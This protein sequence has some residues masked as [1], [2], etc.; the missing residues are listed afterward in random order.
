[1]AVN[2]EG[3]HREGWFMTT[4]KSSEAK[5]AG[6]T[7]QVR[8]DLGADH[9]AAVEF[10]NPPSNFFDVGL[11]EAL[12]DA[13]EEAAG[14]GAR[15]VVLSGAGQVFC[16]GAEFPEHPSGEIDPAELYAAALRLFEQPLPMVAAIQGAAIGGGLG[17]ALAADFRV[18]G[19]AAKF[20]ANFAALGIHPGFGLSVTLPRVAGHQVAAD[21]L[22]TGRRVRAEEALALG[23]V[24]RLCAADDLPQVARELAAEIASSAPLAVASVR[25]TLRAGLIAQVSSAV[26]HERDEQR[27]LFRTQDFQEGVRAVSERRP[28]RF[29]GC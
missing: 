29:Q 16:A 4:A 18:A 22:M 12:V 19:P 11:I 23:L 8:L 20:A 24:D 14:S 6:D 17:L 25:R 26:Q 21:L 13:C 15:A 7:G 28:G 27:K 9:V 10:S 3:R 1:M 5:P 2:D